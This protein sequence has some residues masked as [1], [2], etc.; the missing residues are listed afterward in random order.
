MTRYFVNYI[1][2][3]EVRELRKT[4]HERPIGEYE[5]GEKIMSHLG[6]VVQQYVGLASTPAQDVIDNPPEVIGIS[7][8]EQPGHGTI[9]WMTR[10]LILSWIKPRKEL[11][12]EVPGC[13]R[14]YVGG[15]E[16]KSGW[17]SFYAQSPCYAIANLKLNDGRTLN[18]VPDEEL[19]TLFAEVD[20]ENFK[21]DP[22]LNDGLV[23]A[24][25]FRQF[26]VAS[27]IVATAEETITSSS[28]LT[29]RKF[30]EAQFEAEE[31]DK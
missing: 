10:P 30:S 18:E 15:E 16:E 7:K 17:M 24:T 12:F 14:E 6:T 8:T 31:E 11:D 20:F 2:D 3:E 1:D 13:T 22:H 21:F 26:K 23:P 29:K 9:W 19:Q 28:S 5:D 25:A 4:Q 27:N